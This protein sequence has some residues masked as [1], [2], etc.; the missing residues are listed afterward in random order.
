MPEINMSK[1]PMI[2]QTKDYTGASACVINIFHYYGKVIEFD[3]KYLDGL[4]SKNFKNPNQE[5]SMFNKICLIFDK[6]DPDFECIYK[7]CSG[8]LKKLEKYLKFNIQQK[9]R[10]LIAIKTR[11]NPNC[12]HIVCIIGYNESYFKYFDPDPG[13]GIEKVN[14]LNNE[15]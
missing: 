3:D 14:Y 6:I 5:L 7:N 15:F 8:E 10:V 1:F 13:Y 11:N 9:T 4:I 2:N 12:T